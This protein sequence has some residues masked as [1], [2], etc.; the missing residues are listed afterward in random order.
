VCH[1]AF[2]LHIPVCM[3]RQKAAADVDAIRTQCTAI[4]DQLRAQY[5]AE[6]ESTRNARFEELERLGAG[7][8]AEIEALRDRQASELEVWRSQ[9]GADSEAASTA[10]E[11]HRAEAAQQMELM[12]QE[13]ESLSAQLEDAKSREDHARE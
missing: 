3:C 5:S 1:I 8:N 13:C 2:I 7:K 4:T 11:Q 9:R 6:A 10:L 12:C